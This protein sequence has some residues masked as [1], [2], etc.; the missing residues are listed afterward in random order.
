MSG[1]KK[2]SFEELGLR[3]WLCKQISKLGMKS[4][5]PIQQNCIPE[6]V[7]ILLL[8]KLT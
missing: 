4:S 3:P 1:V 2:K 5:T 7:R 8:K 6:I